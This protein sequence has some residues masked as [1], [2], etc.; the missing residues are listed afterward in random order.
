M[1]TKLILLNVLV[2]ITSCAHSQTQPASGGQ[3]IL[4]VYFSHSGNT[5]AIAEQIRNATGADIFEIQP[6]NAYPKD[7]KAVV[8]QAKKE[9]SSNYKPELKTKIENIGQYD[10]IFIG[11]PNWCSTMAPP[12]NTFLSEYDFSGKTL[13]PFMT[14]GGGV[15]GHYIADLKN[16][17]PKST[18][19]E[20]IAIS[21]RSIKDSQNE[22]LKWLKQIKVIN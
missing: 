10:V 6:V 16:L 18:F 17:C 14:H 19:L 20:G 15:F 4:V 9:I 21:D 22:I 11:S 2:M 1:K 7:Y 5:K 3:K 13:V 8:D 12:M